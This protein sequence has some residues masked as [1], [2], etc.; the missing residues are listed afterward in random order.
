[1]GVIDVASVL[2]EDADVSDPNVTLTDLYT[3]RVEFTFPEGVSES[4]AKSMSFILR[5]TGEDVTENDFIENE[6]T[7][8]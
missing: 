5:K 3:G 2:P 8:E 6:T 4:E 7:G 1:M